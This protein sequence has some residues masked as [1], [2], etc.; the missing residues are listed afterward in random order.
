MAAEPRSRVPRRVAPW[1]RVGRRGL[2]VALIAACLLAGW[3]W[4]RDAAVVRV[5]QVR[6]SGVSSTQADDVRAA[7][8]DAGR[9]MT[10]LHVREDQL[11]AAIAPYKTVAG[12]KADGDFPHTL[13][14]RVREHPLVASVATAGA[15][16]PVI[17]DGSLL[18]GVRADPRLPTLDAGR[19]RSSEQL[20]DRRAL[21]AVAVLAAVPGPLRRRVS[22]AKHESRGLTLQMR[23]GPDL[24]FGD[25][26]RVRAKWAAAT[27]VLAEPT[28]VGAVYLDLRV[29]ER[30]AAGGVAPEPEPEAT[31]DPAPA[32][33][34][35]SVPSTT[36]PVVP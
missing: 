27:R 2:L 17:A 28:A 30:V 36:D 16:V 14:V 11:M 34:T 29:P 9:D 35:P 23:S 15:R 22:G 33:E 13:D 7:L 5:E 21:A 19:L 31:A 26:T 20:G 8:T 32:P 10:T 25:A 12:L 18:V 24:I 3:L 6:I 4:L 1:T